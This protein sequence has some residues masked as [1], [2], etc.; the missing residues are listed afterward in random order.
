V[1]RV[2]VLVFAIAGLAFGAKDEVCATCHRAI[3]DSYESTPMARSSGSVT[4]EQAPT[5]SGQA[6][7]AAGSSF[8]IGP[9]ADVEITAEGRLA[10][11]RLRYFIGAGVTGRSFLYDIDNYLFQSP[12]AWYSAVHQWNLSPGY[13]KSAR[14][15]LMRPVEASCLNCHATGIHPVANTLNRYQQPP[16][17]HSGITCERCHGSAENHLARTGNKKDPGVVNPAKLDFARRDSVCAHCHLI[18]VVRIAKTRE[19]PYSPGDQLF[20]STAVFLWSEGTRPLPA[21]SHFEQMAR[22]ACWRV[23]QGRLWCGTCHDPHRVIAP[24]ERAQYYRDRCATC[25]A[26]SAPACAFPI[27]RRREAQDNCIACHMV[28]RPAATVQHAAQ[29]DHTI[30]RRPTTSPL[31][32]AIP[33]NAELTPFPGSTATDRETGL[34]YAEEALTHNNRRLG[35][36]ALELLSPVYSAHANDAQVADQYA[37]L[38]DKAGRQNQ[39]CEIF[40]RLSGNSDAPAAAMIN[41]GTCLADAAR[42]EQAIALWKKAIEKNPAEESARLNLAVALYRTG[43]TV[44]ARATL[45]EALRLDPFFTRARD[46]LAEIH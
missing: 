5:N 13:E 30:P 19:R 15:N 36:R 2:S 42:P 26:R 7:E 3:Y 18:G 38:L 32:T 46:L 23:S 41:A 28:A 45:E 1:F 8:R 11:H 17:E 16:F 37:Q 22:S 24:A 12:V 9:D 10:A 21:N 20:D 6:F 27:A 34:A 33:D 4:A 31:L 39:A 43:D 25:H 14:V 29:T 40:Q 44:Q 35:V